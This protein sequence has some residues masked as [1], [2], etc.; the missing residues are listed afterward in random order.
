MP[1]YEYR[2]QVCGHRFSRLSRV[3]LGADEETPPPCPACASADT[4]RTVSGFAVGGPGGPDAAEAAQQRAQDERAASITPREQIE[5]WR[6]A[7]S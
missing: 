6:Q 1:I 7:Q 3:V 4:A 5:N 2:C